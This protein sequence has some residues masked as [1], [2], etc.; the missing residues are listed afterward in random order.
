MSGL[1]WLAVVTIVELAALEDEPAPAGAELLG[2]GLVEL[3]LEGLEIAEVGL[4]LVQRER[5][6]ARRPPV[7]RA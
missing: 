7:G 4:D 1:S 3:L 5:R 6:W 2:C